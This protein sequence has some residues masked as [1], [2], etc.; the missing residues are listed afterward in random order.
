MTEDREQKDKS[1]NVTYTNKYMCTT[2]QLIIC[3]LNFHATFR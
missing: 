3:D 1:N 2:Y